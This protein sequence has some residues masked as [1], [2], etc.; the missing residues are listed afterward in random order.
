ME[1]MWIKTWV[2]N[3]PYRQADEWDGCR[4]G[5]APLGSQGHLV[6]VVMWLNDSY[7]GLELAG[8]DILSTLRAP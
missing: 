6:A 7:P 5:R 1:S 3:K 8:P 4:P 2:E